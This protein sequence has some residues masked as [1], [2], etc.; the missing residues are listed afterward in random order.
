ML[1]YVN[2]DIVTA[3]VPDEITLAIE[4]SNCPCHCEGCHSD[5]LAQD[6]GDELTYDVIHS[7]LLENKGVTCIALMGGDGDYDSLCE[8]LKLLY[9][10]PQKRC[11]Y[12]GRTV[13]Y[14]RGL[15]DTHNEIFSNIIRYLDYIKI[16]PYIP[17]KGGLAQTTTNQK[18]YKLNHQESG[19]IKFE[20]ITSKFWNT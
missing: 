20:N 9:W 14:L 18:F 7:L 13:D 10:L 8:L 2:Y 4:I 1:K 12:T 3:E 15:D 17:T 16:G 11:W 6:I 5:F 19:S